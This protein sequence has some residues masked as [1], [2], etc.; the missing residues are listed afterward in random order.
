MTP[1]AATIRFTPHAK[2]HLIE[3]WRYSQARWGD[4]RASRYLRTLDDAIR[5]VA[6]GKRKL[7]RCEQYGAGLH[8]LRTQSHNIYLRYDAAGGVLH[9]IGVLHK[10]MDPARHLKHDDEERGDGND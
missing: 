4:E 9:V 3:I 2:L 7:R 1:N 5:A 8:F 10:R 6:L